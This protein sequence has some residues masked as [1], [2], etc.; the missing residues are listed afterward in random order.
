ML[1]HAQAEAL[2][3]LAFGLLDDDPAIQRGLQLLVED[4][5]AA[6]AAVMQQADGGHVGQGPANPYVRGRR[7]P[8]LARNRLSAPMT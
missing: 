6:Q 7:A 1:V 2:G 5:A 3:E 8:G 4:V